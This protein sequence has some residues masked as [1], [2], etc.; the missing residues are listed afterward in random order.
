MSRFIWT[1]RLSLL[2]ILPAAIL[3][4]CDYNRQTSETHE[5]YNSGNYQE[6]AQVATEQAD[7]APKRDALVLR[8]EEGALDRAAAELPA[9]NT[10]FHQAD[11][12]PTAYDDEPETKVSQEAVAAL[13]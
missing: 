3:A 12:L 6:A 2:A 1:K 13:V 7:K 9:S 5:L 4:G 11:D 10:A 8:L